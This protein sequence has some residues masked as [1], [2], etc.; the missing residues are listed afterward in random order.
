ME[1]WYLVGRLEGWSPREGGGDGEG[2]VQWG[3]GRRFPCAGQGSG[4]PCRVEVC[5]HV[6]K[7][8]LV[9]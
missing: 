9:F 5:T 6:Y 1:D 3:A 4:V 8:W 2:L 7:V